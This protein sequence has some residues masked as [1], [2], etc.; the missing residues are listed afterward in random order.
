M[1]KTIWTIL[2][3]VGFV[4][5]AGF[6][7]WNILFKYVS[8][9]ELFQSG[10]YCS[11][12]LNLIPFHD[13]IEGNFNRLDVFGNLI[14]FIPFG[15]YI[16]LLL[17]NKGVGFVILLACLTSI[18]LELFQYVFGIGASDVTDVIYNTLGAMLG[19]GLFGVMKLVFKEEARI[20]C[21]VTFLST[22]TVVLLSILIVMLAIY[23]M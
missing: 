20:Y 12:T 4:F 9:L 19:L 22:I 16:K 13:L 1:K 14:L 7:L 11:R 3:W 17:K 21:F 23:N 15:V 5:Y 18:E 2:F 6:L 8:P 10:R